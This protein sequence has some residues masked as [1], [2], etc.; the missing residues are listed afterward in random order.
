[1]LTALIVSVPVNFL[2][3]DG[4]TGNKWGDGVINYLLEHDWPAPVCS[5]LGQQATAG[6]AIFRIT[7]SRGRSATRTARSIP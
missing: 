7:R 2:F 1:M 4:Y 5:I 6:S 3:S